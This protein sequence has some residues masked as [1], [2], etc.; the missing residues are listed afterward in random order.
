MHEAGIATYAF[1]GPILPHF[2]NN[3]AKITQLLDTLQE[4]GVK[5][6]W[7]EHIN[8]SPKIKARLF[9]FLQKESPDLIPEFERANTQEYRDH[10]DRVITQTM[11]GRGLRMGL[12]KVIHHRSLPKKK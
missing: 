7:F 11:E 10:L 8:L 5:E 12:G 9:A 1:I 2:T 6:V 3:E 4:V